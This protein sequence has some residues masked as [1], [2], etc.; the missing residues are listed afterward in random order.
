MEN[1]AKNSN[2]LIVSEIELSYKSRVKAS[3]RPQITSSKSAYEIAL[4]LWNPN[5]IELFEEFKILLLN[6]SNKVLGAYEVSSGGITGTVVDLR[7]IFAAA[8]KANATA[9][10]MI[11]NHPSGKLIASDADNQ[12]TAKV[13]AAGKLLDIQLLDHLIIT[14][15]NYYSFTDE[16]AL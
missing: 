8:L 9:I 6:N 7:L 1:H 3:E 14:R 5:T 16:G 13:K 4:Q 11:H 15:E 12:I 2:W 10:I